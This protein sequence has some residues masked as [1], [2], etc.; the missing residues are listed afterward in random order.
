MRTDIIDFTKYTV[1]ARRGEFLVDLMKLC[2]QLEN[3]IME[4]ISAGVV[5]RAATSPSVAFK[6]MCRI[7][8]AVVNIHHVENYSG[9]KREFVFPRQVIMYAMKIQ[10]PNFAYASIGKLFS[11]EFDHATVIFAVNKVEEQASVDKQYANLVRQILE[12]LD[13]AGY[14]APLEHFNTIAK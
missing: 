2:P 9:R 14:C 1:P 3:D 6:D 13:S 10:Y 7:V 8:G 5:S 11:H 4:I 12:A